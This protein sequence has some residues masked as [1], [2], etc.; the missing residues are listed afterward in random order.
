MTGR[1]A[2]RAPSAANVTCGQVRSDEPK[3]RVRVVKEGVESINSHATRHALECKRDI[4]SKPGVGMRHALG[5]KRYR[6]LGQGVESTEDESDV[7]PHLDL[8]IMQRLDQTSDRFLRDGNRL[9]P[10]GRSQFADLRL[11]ISKP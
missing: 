8:W 11:G 7:C 10:S 9:H 1:C 2:A 5:K 4:Q 6:F 3:A